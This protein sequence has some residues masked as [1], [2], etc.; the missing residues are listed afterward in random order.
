[1]DLSIICVN[2]NSLDYLRECISSIYEHTHDISFEIIVVDNASPTGDVD[3]LKWQFPAVKL[4]KS[5]VNLGFGGANNL[6]FRH[7][8]GKFILF[9]NP[10]TKLLEPAI[11]CL[12]ECVKPLANAGIVGCKLLNADLSIQTSCIMTF[13]TVWNVLVGAEY[14]RLRWPHLW[15]LGPLFSNSPEPA[16]VQA[17]S[18]ACMLVLREAFEAVGM[19]S[20]DYFMYFED[21]DLCYKAKQ[22]GLQNYFVPQA[23]IVHYAG[24][25][26]A[27]EWQTVM[28]Q[29]A[30]L[31][32]CDRNYGRFYAWLFRIVSIGNAAMRLMM[33]AFLSLLDK[34]NNWKMTSTKWKTNLRALLTY[35]S[36][37]MPSSPGRE[38][39]AMAGMQ[40]T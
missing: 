11:N 28:K 34:K 39:I 40:R 24:T 22:A 29:N 13:P 19:F 15:G 33:V 38:D 16:T 20:E 5:T 4:V 6:G 14:F 1:M 3:S 10:D 7:S 12:L 21:L 31:R 35:S 36:S 32:F 26:S 18:G 8:F 9:L 23:E 37:S 27:S 30:Q 2:W 17:V 25:S